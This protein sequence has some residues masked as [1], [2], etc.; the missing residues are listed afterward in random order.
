MRHTVEEVRK[1]WDSHLNLTQF[2]SEE[3]TTLPPDELYRRLESTLD[4]YD[5][6]KKLLERF[7]QG[8]QGRSLLEVGC[9]L[10]VELGRQRTH[11][12]VQAGTSGL[13]GD[14]QRAGQES[15]PGGSQRESGEVRLL[16]EP[17]WA[18]R[19]VKHEGDGP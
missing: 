9:G 11:P 14:R 2:L 16:R 6:K 17:A 18:G 4:R 7:A 8:M 12:F 1:Y 13:P 3:E 10:G 15:E 5:Y 19:E